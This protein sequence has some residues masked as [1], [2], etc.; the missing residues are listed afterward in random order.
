MLLLS[1]PLKAYINKNYHDDYNLI[2]LHTNADLVEH[3]QTDLMLNTIAKNINI[4][5]I[6]FTD[7]IKSASD[8]S[9]LYYRFDAHF[10]KTGNRIFA[11]YV[12]DYIIK[13]ITPK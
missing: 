7:K 8:T 6:S 5:F 4:P 11:S 12:E 2:G 3:N 10:T 9:K 13:N 1:M